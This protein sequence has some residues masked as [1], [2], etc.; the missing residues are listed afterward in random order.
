MNNSH[1]VRLGGD[2]IALLD[3]PLDG[4]EGNFLLRITNHFVAMNKKNTT[5]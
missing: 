1:F 3:R 2:S 4:A 5:Q